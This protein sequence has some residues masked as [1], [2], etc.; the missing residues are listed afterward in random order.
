M[1]LLFEATDDIVW[2][3]TTDLNWTSRLYSKTI[4]QPGVSVAIRPLSVYTEHNLVP[5]LQKENI[6]TSLFSTDILEPSAINELI[7]FSLSSNETIEAYIQKDDAKIKLFSVDDLQSKFQYISSFPII[8][9]W[10]FNQRYLLFPREIR[11]VKV[12]NENRTIKI[13]G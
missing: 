13:F 8:T 7:E 11:K 6:V 5:V 12:S 10:L 3:S 2:E 1:S 4:G 9:Y